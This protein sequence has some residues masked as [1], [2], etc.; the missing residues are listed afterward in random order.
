MNGIRIRKTGAPDVIAA[1]D[2]RLTLSMPIRIKR[3]SGR[4]LVTLP[5]GEAAN[6]RPWDV[7]ATPMQLALARGYR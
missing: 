4:K 5:N 1:S 6:P 7:E 2:G 3:R